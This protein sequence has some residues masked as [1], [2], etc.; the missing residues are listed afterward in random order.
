MENRNN[1]FRRKHFSTIDRLLIRLTTIAV[2]LLVVVQA[3]LLHA[4]TRKYLSLVD[5]L[6]GEQLTSPP[7]MYAA[8]ISQVDPNKIMTTVD[9]VI[10]KSIR[11]L[12]Y[13]QAITIR[14][15]TPAAAGDGLLT[16]NGEV[17]GNFAKGNLEVTVYNGDYIEIDVTKLTGP[18]QFIIDTHKNERILLPLDGILL[19]SQSNVIVVGKVI[20]KR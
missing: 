19:Q 3:L 17:V 5:K 1:R 6:E 11:S 7:T 18:A 15:I 4:E 2:I 10:A 9:N 12:R 20:L 14:M 8:D 16:I 13:G